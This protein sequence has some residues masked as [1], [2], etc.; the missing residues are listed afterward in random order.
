MPL[1]MLHPCSNAMVTR[2][3]SILLSPLNNVTVSSL[4]IISGHALPLGAIF[5][6]PRHNHLLPSSLSHASHSRPCLVLHTTPSSYHA[7]ASYHASASICNGAACST[8]LYFLTLR[9]SELAVVCCRTK[10]CSTQLPWLGSKPVR[11]DFTLFQ[12][13]V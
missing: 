3:P 12:T 9:K 5:T 13:L 8:C 6:L 1:L 10:H 7:P 2:S 4:L 11:Q